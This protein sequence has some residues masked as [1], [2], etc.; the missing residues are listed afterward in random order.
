MKLKVGDKAPDFKLESVDGPV[1][2]TD[3]KRKKVVVYFYPKDNT[4]GCTIEAIDFSKYKKDF[5]KVGA[6]VIGISKDDCNSHRKFIK[7][8]ELTIILLSD[9]DSAVQEK[10]GVWGKKKFMG[11]EY[12]GTIRSTFLL[13]EKGKILEIWTNVR[14]KDHAKEVLDKVKQI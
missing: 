8:K 6:V 13:D 1:K 2:L 5:E 3:F 9:E 7:G 11:R 14:V 4:E 10:Y 12:I